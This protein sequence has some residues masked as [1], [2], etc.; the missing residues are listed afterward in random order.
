MIKLTFL[1]AGVPLTKTISATT[2]TNYPN[3]K[4]FTSTEHKITAISELFKHITHYAKLGHC[5]LKGT[6]S[7]PLNNEPR[8]G[9]MPPNTL[10]Q[11]VCL[12]LD[13]APFS[14]PDEFMNA[15]KLNDISHV[16]QYSSSYGI[17]KTKNLS[18]HIF[19]LL[20]K[21]LAPMQLKAWLMHLNLSLPALDK[22]IRLSDSCSALH[23]PLDITT[24]QNDK[25]LYIATPIFDGIKD[26][27]TTSRIQLIPR[28]NPSLDVSH[29][30]LRPLEALKK[31]QRKKLNTLRAA[32][33]LDAIT[34]K[35]KIIDDIT[36]QPG[37]GEVSSYDIV[38]ETDEFIR[39]NLNTGDS[40]AYY[41]IKA[42]YELLRNFKGED[43][44]YLKES[45]PDLFKQLN[46]STRSNLQST[47]ANGDVVLAVRDKT[48]GQY[49]KGLYN[50]KRLELYP[51][52][53]KD[54]LHDFLQGHGLVPPPF[55]PEWDVIF[56][57]H[58][59]VIVDEDARIINRFVPTT[60]MKSPTPG[61]YPTIQRFIDHA[62]GVG[63]IQEHFL[64]WLAV[65]MQHRI[66]TKTAWI[67]HG[68][69]GTGKG[70]LVNKVLRGIFE[71]YVC[72]IS[73]DDLNSEFNQWLEKSLIIFVDEIEVD[74]FE[75]KATEG[76]LRRMVTDSPQPI[77]RMR[78]DTYDA[79]NFSNFIFASNKPQPVRIPLTDRR[80]NVGQ[81][82]SRR[83]VST[84]KEIEITIQS[85]ISA[86]AH[87][88]LTRKACIDTASQVLKTEDRAAIQALSIT[89]VDELANNLH[90]GNLEA[91]IESMP[92]ESVNTDPIAVA[93]AHLVRSFT[94]GENRIT[95]D[96]LAI[97]F[98]HCIGKI[99]EGTKKFTMFLRHH[100]IITKRL[101]Y[102]GLLTYG[103]EV[104]WQKHEALPTPS[105]AM[106]RIK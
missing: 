97:I 67:L 101:R 55:V 76:K 51:I 6:L 81:Y 4:N 50:T 58:N 47:S 48:T 69:E 100:G 98:Q 22:G 62:V 28:A 77:R 3:A 1:S 80:Y 29:I 94:N 18:C 104:K 38:E 68:T 45:V 11:Y 93:Y 105:K 20:S 106:R 32:K 16:V 8:K 64:N 73:S 89:S 27:L 57:P 31:E 83:L 15:V 26:P 13:D 30:E 75:K 39:L 36:I 54:K 74:T 9:M 60:L 82:Q 10:T 61:K 102:E 25:L 85:E 59:P 44:T 99:P 96:Q 24:C 42:D 91:L 86:F 95:R 72:V 71:S 66:K 41:V 34:S 65:I 7:A 5:L 2:K 63:P 88:L 46:S 19:L 37:A 43:F 17:K 79:P 87:H 92:D 33:G 14:T 21:P 49:W 103:I 52:D 90:E 56:D 70:V 53:S 78:T 84:H 12:D 40:N 23:W 35:V